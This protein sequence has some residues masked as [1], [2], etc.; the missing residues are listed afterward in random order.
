MFRFFLLS[1]APSSP[2]RTELKTPKTSRK[3]N[4]ISGRFLNR[5]IRGTELASRKRWLE[6]SLFSKTISVLSDFGCSAPTQ[7]RLLQVAQFRRFSPS[8]DFGGAINNRR[9]SCQRVLNF[10]TSIN[11]IHLRRPEIILLSNSA[12]FN[13]KIEPITPPSPHH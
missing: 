10:V 6:N 11:T 5:Q 3:Y 1:A 9:V 4:E 2:H 8:R 7:S 13:E 12:A